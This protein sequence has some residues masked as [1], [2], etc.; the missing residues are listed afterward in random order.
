MWPFRKR[1]QPEK[2]TV[3]NKALEQQKQATDRLYR[4]MRHAQ[5]E[6]INEVFAQAMPHHEKG[7]KD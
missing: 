3:L 7:S 6:R 2:I 1:K 5:T 4:A